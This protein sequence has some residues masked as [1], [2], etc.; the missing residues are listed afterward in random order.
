MRDR[1]TSDRDRTCAAARAP[2]ATIE[3]SPARILA[4]RDYRQKVSFAGSWC[5]Y[6]WRLTNPTG[7]ST[8]TAFETVALYCDDWQNKSD[9]FSDVPLADDFEFIGPVASFDNAAG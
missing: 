8:M 7:G 9:D 2:G 5:L 4:L 1:V 6:R 3:G